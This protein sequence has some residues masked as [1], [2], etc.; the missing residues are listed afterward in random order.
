LAVRRGVL[1]GLQ[2]RHFLPVHL[3]PDTPEGLAVDIPDLVGSREPVAIKA[4]HSDDRLSLEVWVSDVHDG[5][6]RLHTELP[7]RG[8]GR[9]K[10]VLTGLEPGTYHVSVTG[11]ADGQ[12]QRLSELVTVH[13]GLP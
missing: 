11:F 12:P 5:T 6:D 7:N 4:R 2:I 1:R 3:G 8:G 13:G 10:A 9:Y